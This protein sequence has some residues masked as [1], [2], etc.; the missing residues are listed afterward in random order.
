[1]ADFYWAQAEKKYNTSLK[2][3]VVSASK[4]ILK[5]EVCK[6]TYETIKKNSIAKNETI[7]GKGQK[8]K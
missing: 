6:R 3:Y 1:M 5:I 2:H 4:E 7:L 8:Q